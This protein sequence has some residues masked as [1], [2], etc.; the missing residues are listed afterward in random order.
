MDTLD[1]Q[2]LRETKLEKYC[3]LD[4]RISLW[5]WLWRDLKEDLPKAEWVHFQRFLSMT[6]SWSEGSESTSESRIR[7]GF[8][9]RQLSDNRRCLSSRDKKSGTLSDQ[10]SQLNPYRAKKFWMVGYKWRRLHIIKKGII[11]YYYQNYGM[12]LY[13]KNEVLR[14]KRSLLSWK[15]GEDS[16]WSD[17]GYW[18]KEAGKRG[19]RR[20]YVWP[21]QEWFLLWV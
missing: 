8:A 5:Y 18:K 7:F 15:S 12:E 16:E 1:C 19:V 6:N 10:E 21:S 3:F 14:L 17:K 20:G 4:V 9:F 13:E 11:V 2:K